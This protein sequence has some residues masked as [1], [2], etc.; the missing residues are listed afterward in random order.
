MRV[1]VLGGSDRVHGS[2][3]LGRAC[4]RGRDRPDRRHIHAH[5]E[6]RVCVGGTEHLHDR[7]KPGTTLRSASKSSIAV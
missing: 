5:A 7:F 4:E 2:D 3:R 1:L 6:S